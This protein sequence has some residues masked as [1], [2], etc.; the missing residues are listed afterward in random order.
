[1]KP[2]RA[3]EAVWFW[4]EDDVLYVLSSP[5]GAGRV[6]GTEA[7]TARIV[8][9]ELTRLGVIYSVDTV[10]L[11]P[12]TRPTTTTQTSQLANQNGLGDI[13]SESESNLTYFPPTDSTVTNQNR[14][15]VLDTEATLG[16][17]GGSSSAFLV[18][19]VI[20]GLYGLKIIP[21]IK[22]II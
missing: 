6:G 8:D 16:S 14:E 15:K 11:L 3:G 17:G 10:L 9:W 7:V 22:Y 12:P 2:L 18:M 5:E 1:M 21:L 4:S 20:L 13:P 19:F